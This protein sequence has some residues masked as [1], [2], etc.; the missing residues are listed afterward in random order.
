MVYLIA[1]LVIV[2]ILIISTFC[3]TNVRFGKKNKAVLEEVEMR[4]NVALELKNITKIYGTD[5][6]KVTALSDVS[7]AFRKSEFVSVLGPSGC[8]KTTMLNIVGGLDRYTSGDILIGGVSTKEYTDSDWDTYR[9]NRIGFVF[10]TYNLIMHQS[11]I[12]NVELALTLSGISKEE[13]RNRA[14]KVLE[15]VGLKGQEHKRPNQLSGGQMQ[16]VAIARALVNNPD[17]ILADEPTGALDTET[18]I[19]IMELLKEVASDRLVIMVTHNP[20]LAKRY[21][22]RIINLLDGEMTGDTNSLD[23]EKAPKVT[24]KKQVKQKQSSMK[25]ATAFKL[26]LSNL[27]TKKGRTALTSIAGSIGIIGIALVL[28]VS[29]GFSGYIN[30]LQA[31]TLST[32]P[33]TVSESSVDLTDFNKLLEDT[34]LNKYPKVKEVYSKEFFKNLTNMLKS[35]NISEE[36]LAFVDEYLEKE[37][38]KARETDRKWKY[39]L[40]EGYGF[41]MNNFIYTEIGFN[42]G[43]YKEGEENPLMRT[44]MPI[45]MFVRM[46]EN[47]FSS[48]L[49]NSELNISTGFVREYIPTMSEIPDELDLIKSQYDL[50]DGDWAT[51]E[52]ELMLVVDSSNRIPD[53][54]L[55]F[56]GIKT[57]EGTTGEGS[58]IHFG[59]KDEFTFQE[60]SEKT[61]YYVEND[62]RYNKVT[63]RQNTYFE[64]GFKE[65]A[66]PDGALPLKIK[67]IIR[68]K[69]D[70]SQGV[71]NQGIAYTSK[72]VQRVIADNIDSQIVQDLSDKDKVEIY[73]LPDYETTSL[74]NNLIDMLISAGTLNNI[75][76]PNNKISPIS[77]SRAELGG[78]DK[79]IKLSFYSIDYEAKESLKK[80]LDSWNTVEG[81]EEKDEVHYSDP[82][83]MLFSA[84]NMM[85]DG[86][87]IVLVAFT[88]ISLIVSSIMI[89][90]ITYVSVVERTKEIGVL[91][92]L[93]A[94]K[95]DV[96]RIFN[97]ET[98][99]IGLFAG[100]LGIGITYLLSIPLNLLISGLIGAKSIC[101]LRITDA[102]ILVVVSFVLT[103]ISGVI[104]A[105]IASKK[106]P[107]VALRTE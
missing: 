103:L 41:D 106:D 47:M 7:L 53:I 88:S 105:R 36:Y 5:D 48:R 26:S 30:D 91:R 65:D 35:N 3:F 43:A 74:P 81:R 16:R 12:S 33:L 59:G 66:M 6:N 37:N 44:T 92:S 29:T 15:Q 38:A 10:Q 52:D 40:T 45:D 39:S 102:L 90:I 93:G 76:P 18:S 22:T 60:I 32:Y 25:F 14:K 84:M 80:H 56:L 85:V 61:F 98:F 79:I 57:I 100:L 72:L 34:G 21:S 64:R 23:I 78:S 27:R 94:R 75:L 19:Q 83:D 107:V 31:N 8:G 96:S 67:G 73:P 20:E 46:M 58:Q 104:P 9:N 13:R 97:A 86:V 87:K 4:E 42:T 2:G 54:S 69:E 62:I 11:V 50:L 17:I 95:R 82:S 55:V 77:S 68:I 1:S 89:G 28:A 70:A 49:E 24:V 99:I 63:G 51:E 101:S 71:L